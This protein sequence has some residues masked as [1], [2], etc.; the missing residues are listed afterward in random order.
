MA[1]RGVNKVILIGRL[2]KDPEVRYLPNGNAVAN[3][4]LA[5]SESW[6]DKQTGEQVQK[7]EWHRVSFFS[8]L[9]EIA[10]EY[11]RK[12]SKIY[13]EGRIQYRKY[14]DQGGIERWA[15]D[16]VAHEMQMLD[17]RSSGGTTGFE[18]SQ[19]NSYSS[20]NNI[21]QQTNNQAPV[22]NQTTP[23][24]SVP[25]GNYATPNTAVTP[26]TPV[27]NQATTPSSSPGG[28]VYDDDIPF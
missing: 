6:K 10:G 23:N 25:A 13:I 14:Q 17:S 7:T 4:A 3:V 22:N 8:R 26:S 5:T 19:G 2:G 15:T 27:N 1:E 18:Q 24:A 28:E 9:A 16:I 12:G 20:N 11:L 21:P